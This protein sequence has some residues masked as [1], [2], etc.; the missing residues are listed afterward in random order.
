MKGNDLRRKV[1]L[2]EMISEGCEIE[3]KQFEA[4]DI[5]VDKDLIH[6]HSKQTP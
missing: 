2:L 6:A 4:Q 1:E 5:D 3:I